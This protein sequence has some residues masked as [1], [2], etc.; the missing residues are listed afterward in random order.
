M[1]N[2]LVKTG[3]WSLQSSHTSVPGHIGT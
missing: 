1:Y 3:V 2:K